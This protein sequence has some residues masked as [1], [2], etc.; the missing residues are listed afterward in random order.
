MLILI[1][2]VSGLLGKILARTGLE[3]GHRIRGF[4]RSPSKI[5]AELLDKFESFVECEYYEDR[6]ALDKAVSGVDAV[7]CSYT[8]HAEAILDSQLALLRAVERAGVK[9]YHAHSWNPDWS[10]TSLG[11]WEHYDAY[12]SFR[13]HVELT[14]T[15]KP[16]Y[17][18][19]GI[20]GEYAVSKIVGI[21]HVEDDADTDTDG[22]GGRK[23]VAYYGD[24]TAKWDFTYL[25]DAARFSIDL[26]TTNPSVLAGEGGIFRIHSAAASALD[27]ARAYE[28][29]TGQGVALRS[30][31]TAE[32]LLQKYREARAATR[33]PRQYFVYGPYYVHAANIMG[34]WRLDNPVE[35][36]SVDAVNRLFDRQIDIAA[37]LL[38]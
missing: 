23:T 11:D 4:G 5:P 16:V 30:L 22:N 34:L 6:L 8:A 36:G 38:E 3:K 15:L 21:A 33:D 12:I 10:R 14:S 2:G 31:G 28:E 20:I 1:A 35:V 17:T 37:D 19:T 29:N 32:H 27:V 18:F 9:V 24:G 7:I 26:I 13:R 25:D